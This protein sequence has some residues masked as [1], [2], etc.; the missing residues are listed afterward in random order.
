MRPQDTISFTAA[1]GVSPD[2]ISQS[3]ANW[4]LYQQLSDHAKGARASAAANI[5]NAAVMCFVF[6]GELNVWIMFFGF[7]TMF[8]LIGH[9]LWI[10]AKVPPVYE[11]GGI[12]IQKI[13][14]HIERNTWLLGGWW[15]L[16]IGI[17]LVDVTHEQQL[18][19]GIIG[20]GMMAAGTISF[21]TLERPA[22]IFVGMCAL[23]SLVALITIGTTTS[24]ASC[25][26]LGC[27]SVVLFGAI[28]RGAA[29]FIE[30]KERE[31]ALEVS[32]ETISLLL[33]DYEQQGSDWL[34]EISDLGLIKNPC[35]R[36]AAAS[37]R[38]LET[39]TD[40]QFVELLDYGV[41]QIELMRLIAS[42]Q[43]FR[44]H[45]V[46]L[47]VGQEQHWW[48]ITA[49]PNHGTQGGLR[50]VIT[51]ITA[52]RLAEEKV[53]YM[54]HYDSLTG[55]PNR[56]LF[57]ESLDLALKSDANGAGLMYLDLDH[58]KSIND[59]LGH[60]IGDKLL[61][62]VALRL[63][64]CVRTG[65]LIARLGG[66]E[67]AILVG[68]DNLK[69]IDQLATRIIEAI[70]LPFLI[71]GYEVSTGA[72]IGIAYAPDH[73]DTPEQL[74]KNAD[75]ALYAAKAQGR[76]HFV[77]FEKGMGSLAET[78]R[79]LE[80]DLRSALNRDEMRLHYQPLINVMTGEP[81]GYEAL[82]RWQ[83][84]L[85]GTVLP[86]D[87]IPIAEETGMVIKIGEWVIRRALQEAAT[88]PEHLGVAVNLSPAQMR[89]TSL[90][91]TVIHALAQS[92]VAAHR[93]ELEITESVLMNDT[94]A[95]IA[96]LHRLSAL[97]V[98]IAL[99]DFG[100]GF[101]SLNYLRSFP[102]HKIKIDRCFISEIDSREDCRAIVRSIVSLA[103]NLGMTTT[104]EGVERQS[105]LDALRKEGCTEVQ[106]FLFSKAVSSAELSDLRPITRRRR[107][108]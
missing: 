67:F 7:M 94:E 100:T 62:A 85:R 6:V 29:N 101:S 4:I 34:I 93:L 80:L 14:Q 55:L 88:W 26:L 28:K 66:D 92:G 104:A 48:S 78:R 15:A 46:S 84:Q 23:G 64:A 16:A 86:S 45:I 89:S 47:H 96:I 54:A 1:T 63:E 31:R 32:A 52:Q 108:A 106:G 69:A 70:G 71:D 95:N 22:L 11:G 3:D 30:S 13:Y 107:A 39:L 43:S 82:V 37:G 74:L 19:V 42:R 75:L 51:D 18:L 59:T 40:L 25:I 77:R 99:D 50:G 87:F 76:G 58:F 38:P 9:R 73:G 83:H 49:R 57:N 17:P 27:Y 8:A 72:S 33:N 97:G 60:P 81:S 91:P 12:N 102:F 2:R 21:R 68:G 90:V 10:N 65:D 44:D 103:N 79:E 41:A 5:I 61:N 35:E 53:R 36:L 24:Y 56:F 20:A 98:R 105:Q